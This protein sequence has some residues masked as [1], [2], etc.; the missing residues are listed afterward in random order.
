MKINEMLY[1]IVISTFLIIMCTSCICYATGGSIGEINTGLYKPQFTVG[2]GT[3]NIFST[4]LGVLQ[5]IGIIAIVI[6]IALIGFNTIM[7]SASQK[8]VGQEKIVGLLIA[9]GVLTGGSA[10]AKMIMS[11]AE[12]L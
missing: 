4:I 6:A 9:A 12:S 3:K 11:I 10:L 1:K 5:L 8:A 2:D 7:G